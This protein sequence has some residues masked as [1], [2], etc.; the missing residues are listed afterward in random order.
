M[1]MTVRI[2]LGIIVLFF[3]P[4]LIMAEDAPGYTDTPLIPGSKWK[5]HDQA[6]P[7][8]PKVEPGRGDL[9]RMPPSDAIVLFDGTNLDRWKGPDEAKKNSGIKDGAFDIL[10]TDQL[11]TIEE[12]GD[13]QLHIEWMTPEKPEDR[14]NW[15]NSGVFLLGCIEIQVL[16]SHDSFIYADGNAGAI[17]GQFPP[18]VNPAR[19]PGQWQ[20]FDMIFTAPKIENGKQ[21]EPAYLTLFYNG[22]L[23]QNHREILGKVAHRDVPAPM[24][25]DKGPI[26]LQQHGSAV[27][28]RNI[29]IRPIERES[30]ETPTL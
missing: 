1:T 9:R 7:Q 12:F 10:V 26:V 29:W 15:G 28:F 5:V 6:R 27:K 16:E 8:P 3:A 22:V 23:V 24:N 20:S 25:V 30:M 14:M 19:K 2:S 11:S 21:V 13:C 18:L 4:S 17:Y